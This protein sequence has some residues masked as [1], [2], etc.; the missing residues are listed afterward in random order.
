MWTTCT[1]AVKSIDRCGWL[2]IIIYDLYFSYHMF[3]IYYNQFQ[4]RE[5]SSKNDG[6][7]YSTKTEI[8]NSIQFENVLFLIQQW[9]RDVFNVRPFTYFC[10]WLSSVDVYERSHGYN[11][12]LEHSYPAIWHAFQPVLLTRFKK[13]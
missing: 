7:M 3:F 8:F 2:H 4:T 12:C 11:F 6:E 10:H 13:M 9:R 5:M 1:Q